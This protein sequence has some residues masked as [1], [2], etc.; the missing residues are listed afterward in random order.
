[1]QVDLKMEPIGGL[2]F[3]R[4]LRA[5]ANNPY[6]FVPVIMI[7]TRA[8]ATVSMLACAVIMMTGTKR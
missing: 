6:R 4:Q 1:M 5:D 3:V 2:E 8:K 7:T